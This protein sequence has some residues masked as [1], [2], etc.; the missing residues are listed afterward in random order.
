L[1]AQPTQRIGKLD[2]DVL[3][4]EPHDPL[5]GVDGCFELLSGQT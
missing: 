3:V 1:Y 5:S 4:Q 2:R